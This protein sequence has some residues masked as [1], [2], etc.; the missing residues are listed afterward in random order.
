MK[1]PSEDFIRVVQSFITTYTPKFLEALLNIPDTRK[2]PDSCKYFSF[3]LRVCEL[4]WM[5]TGGMSG[6]YYED[7]LMAPE[8]VDAISSFCAKFCKIPCDENKQF[9]LPT[10]NT[11]QDDMEHMDPLALKNA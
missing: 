9:P 11:L 6:L 7:F 5:L 2:N 10:I 1:N 8:A 3:Q 4:F